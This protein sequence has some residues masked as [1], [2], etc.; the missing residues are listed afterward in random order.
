VSIFNALYLLRVLLAAI[1]CTTVFSMYSPHAG[2]N[3]LAAWSQYGDRGEVEA[4]LVTEESACPDLIADGRPV[5]MTERASPSP[6]FPV[7]ICVAAIPVGTKR[8]TG[9]GIDLPVP[10][11]HPRHIVVF[12]DTGCRLK[13]AVVQ[14]CND[15]TAWP[16]HAIAERAAQA[17]PD[18]M[19]HL[20]DYLFAS[21]PAQRETTAARVRLGVIIGPPGMRIS[22]RR[23]LPFCTARSG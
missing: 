22:S 7:R 11:R 16:F 18:L 17:R 3:T 9:G 15:P 6:A 21:R 13:G 20:G 10:V 23:L 5:S 8:L 2:A 4:R 14:A 12:G 19:I 1:A